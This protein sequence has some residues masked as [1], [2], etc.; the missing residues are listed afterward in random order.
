MPGYYA[1]LIGAD[2]RISKRVAIVC[3]DDEQAKGF[4]KQM[5]DGDAIELWQEARMIATNCEFGCD[6]LRTWRQQADERPTSTN[7]P[8]SDPLYFADVG[9]SGS[10]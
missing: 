2:G 3:D 9:L 4:A 7:L 6:P 5:V 10:E 8:Q 1:Y